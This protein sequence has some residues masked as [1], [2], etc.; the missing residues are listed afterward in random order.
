MCQ[1]SLNARIYQSQNKKIKHVGILFHQALSR[2][3]PPERVIERER[4]NEGQTAIALLKWLCAQIYFDI[5][6]FSVSHKIQT[7]L[8]AA[9]ENVCT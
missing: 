4:E 6:F 1:W 3:S 7:V 2:F 5:V 8:H 9:P